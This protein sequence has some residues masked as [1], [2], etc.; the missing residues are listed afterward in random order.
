MVVIINSLNSLYSTEVKLYDNN[1]KDYQIYVFANE[2]SCGI[3]ISNFHY[4]L[5]T[6]ELSRVNIIY[7][8][9]GINNNDTIQNLKINYNLNFVNDKLGAYSNYYEVPKLP[10]LMLMNNQGKILLE[11][12]LGDGKSDVNVNDVI[13]LINNNSTY[14]EGELKLISRKKIIIEN[15]GITLNSKRFTTYYY[16]DTLIVN[17]SE[18]M[19]YYVVDLNTNEA[20][21]INL[22]KSSIYDFNFSRHPLMNENKILNLDIS[23]KAGY[24]LYDINMRNDEGNISY[25]DINSLLDSNLSYSHEIEI[26]GNKLL[27]GIRSKSDDIYLDQNSPTFV[28][29]DL[30]NKNKIERYGGK[31]SE[32][33]SMYKKSNLLYPYFIYSE[34]NEELYEVQSGSKVFNIFNTNGDFKNSLE[35]NYGT[36][37]KTFVYD[38]RSKDLIFRKNN[39]SLITDFLSFD[40]DTNFCVVYRN[41]YV[42]ENVKKL[43]SSKIKEKYFIHLFNNQ[44]NPLTNSDIQLPANFKPFAIKIKNIMGVEIYKDEAYISI[45]QY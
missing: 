38:V 23:A 35:L 8:Y 40:S 5:E 13:D 21:K 15:K 31:I 19:S 3:C 14:K 26:V 39:Y 10:Y 7:F 27:L 34:I 16:R 45:Y 30:K 20:N 29:L 11:F 18:N 28:L 6:I 17:D 1:D 33:F 32:E 22:Q 36:E 44:G 42:P 9:D 12:K 41:K 24:Y 4:L 43:Y 25:Y 37:F 2:N